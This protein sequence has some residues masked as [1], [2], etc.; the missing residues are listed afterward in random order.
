MEWNGMFHDI[1]FWNRT[2]FTASVDI[3]YSSAVPYI[4]IYMYTVVTCMDTQNKLSYA[5]SIFCTGHRDYMQI[6]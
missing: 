3:Y 5:H 1:I 6:N 2:I 4:A